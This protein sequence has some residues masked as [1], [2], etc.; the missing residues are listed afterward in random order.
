MHRQGPGLPS[1]NAGSLQAERDK[2]KKQKVNGDWKP[3]I[4]S[5]VVTTESPQK[6]P[7]LSKMAVTRGKDSLHSVG[8]VITKP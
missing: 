7:Y 8:E 5:W 3:Y 1:S 6:H 4:K 2:F